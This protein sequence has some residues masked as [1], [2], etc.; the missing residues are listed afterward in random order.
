MNV[1]ETSAE[2]LK[3]ELKITVPANELEDQ[4]TRRL[5]EIGRSVRIPG[6]RP[7]KVPLPLLR[8]RF[9]PAVRGEVLESTVQDSSA[10][11][12]REHNLRP[13]LPPRVAIVS[14]VEGAD[15]EYTISVELFPEMPELDF[16]SLGLEKLVAEAPQEDVDRAVE[17]IAEAQRKSEPVERPAAEG[18][19]LVADVVGRVDAEEIAGSRG[20]GRQIELGAEG[21]LPGFTEQLVGVGAG[22]TREVHVTFPEDYGNPELAGKEGVFEVAVKEVR[23][24]LPATLDDELAKAVGLE[25]L[26]ELRQEVRQRIERD[27]AAIARQR[28]KRALLDKLAERYDFAVPPGMVEIEFNSI[29]AQYEADKKRQTE[30]AGEGGGAPGATAE[31]PIDAAALIAPE[32]TALEGASE[33]APP[34]A[35]A[36]KPQQH[37]HVGGAHHAVSHQGSVEEPID[38][39]AI[40]APEETALE[41]ASDSEPSTAAA[42]GEDDEKAKSDFLRVAERRVRLGLLLAEVGRNNNIMVSQEE[43]NQALMQEARRLPGYERQVIDYYR[44]NPEAMSNLRA[45]IF[46]EKVVDF[47]VELAKPDE[48]KVTPQELMSG[49]EPDSE[50]DPAA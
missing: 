26:A 18:D 22:E 15:L 42:E 19:I 14:A 41:G 20:E 34:S 23:Q 38:A 10:E 24:R 39:A 36:E 46:E 21:L 35:E 29:W 32:E 12:M 31:G 8:Q 30:M 9:G 33:R 11:A 45:P 47:I 2:G 3:R 4:I 48:R 43:L 27:Y 28:L 13:A 40:V 17:R 50:S 5:G 6:F 16:S 1:T 25:T 7:G 49:G 37:E 44:K